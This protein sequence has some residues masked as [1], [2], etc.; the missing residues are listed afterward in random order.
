MM[1]CNENS[2]ADCI[3]YYYLLLIDTVINFDDSQIAINNDLL[4]YCTS[5]DWGFHLDNF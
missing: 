5:G 4:R 2:W 3:I 1:S